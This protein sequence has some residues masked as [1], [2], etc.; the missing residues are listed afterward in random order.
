VVGLAVLAAVCAVCAPAIAADDEEEGKRL[1]R[2]GEEFLKAGD[3]RA[4]AQAFEAGYAAAPRV[5]FLLNIGNCYRKLGE[6]SKARQ[7]YWRFLDAAPAEHPS[8]PEVMEYLRGMEQIEADGVGVDG[9]LT[10]P[11]LA[12]PPASATPP[13]RITSGVIDQAPRH[14]VVEVTERRADGPAP[15]Y[16][17]GW[18]WAVVGGVVAASAGTYFLTRRGGIGSCS[19]SLGCVHE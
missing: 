3:Y 10:T 6:L 2:R 12:P 11:A 9:A 4:A 15:F 19:A 1:F 16:R 7:Y 8:R 17:R 5:G 14:P 18:F 13:R